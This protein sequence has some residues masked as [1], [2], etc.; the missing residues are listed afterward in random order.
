MAQENR[1]FGEQIRTARTAKGWSQT[2]LG[3][4][5]GRGQ[6][7]VY[8]VETGKLNVRE[9]LKDKLLNVLGLSTPKRELHP[10]SV[11]LG[12]HRRVIRVPESRR[13]I[14]LFRLKDATPRAIEDWIK[15]SPQYE[16]GQYRA[17]V[18]STTGA[19]HRIPSIFFR[20]GGGKF[21]LKN[22][23]GYFGR[24]SAG[25]SGLADNLCQRFRLGY[26]ERNDSWGMILAVTSIKA[27]LQYEQ[28]GISI[29]KYLVKKR[30]LCISNKTEYPKGNVGTTEPGF[31]YFTF[32]INDASEMDAEVFSPKQTDDAVKKILENPASK[33]LGNQDEIE[34]A[35]LAAFN[36]ANDT[37]FWGDNEVIVNDPKSIRSSHGIKSAWR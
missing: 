13:P 11:S 2:Y 16:N 22:I 10:E 28:F 35:Y 15:Q 7:W 12:A 5:L 1:R 14:Q 6:G 3:K 31:L 17:L 24:S 36:L 37:N 34:R 32:K 27:S 9:D 23:Q 30:G 4:R 8:C 20:G 29:L 25:A 19:I 21:D 18:K 33:G 26:S